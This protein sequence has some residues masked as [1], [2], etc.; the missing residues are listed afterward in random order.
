MGTGSEALGWKNGFRAFHRAKLGSQTTQINTTGCIFLPKI[1]IKYFKTLYL[2]KVERTCIFATA[3]TV[4]IRSLRPK[5]YVIAT[6]YLFP[7]LQNYEDLSIKH[8]IDLV[9]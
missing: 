7:V 6:L 4:L 8:N 2:C 1:Q 5:A 9:R 3:F